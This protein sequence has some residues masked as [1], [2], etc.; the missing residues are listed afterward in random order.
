MSLDVGQVRTQNT[1][2]QQSPGRDPAPLTAEQQAAIQ[3]KAN[4]ATSNP[5]QRE[6]L[7][8]AYTQAE[9]TGDAALLQQADKLATLYRDREILGLSRA[10]APGDTAP[11]GWHKATPE[12]LQQYGI[13]AEELHPSGSGFNAELFIPDARTFGPDA[14]PVLAFEGTNFGDPNDVN[15]DV[16]Q[17]LGNPEEYYNRTMD[18]ATKVAQ[19]TNN[20]VVFSGHSLGGGLATAASQV[21]GAEGIVSNAAGVHPNTTARFLAER[22][23]EAPAEANANI[24]T[25]VVD[26]D[27]L[28]SLQNA[29]SGLSQDNADATAAIFNGVVRGYNFFTGAQLPADA[30]GNELLNLPDAAGNVTVLDAVNADGTARPEIKSLDTILQDIGNS[31]DKLSLPG[32]LLER[33]GGAVNRFL[34]WVDKIVPGNALD[35]FGDWVENAGKSVE[36]VNRIVAT[37]VSSAVQAGAFPEVRNSFGEMVQRHNASVLYG[38]MDN[39]ISQSEQALRSEL[40]G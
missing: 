35:S 2:V 1:V 6:L 31:T 7:V 9:T 30:T 10:L 36:D 13:T 19:R 14:K 33:G 20:Q 39:R 16:A 23:L 11:A 27:I 26:G 24:R 8:Q 22:G 5:Q 38:A 15:A 3:Q 25:Y 12:E 18:L 17:A 37:A 32:E 34:D 21:T 4:A 29:T 40:D 28:T